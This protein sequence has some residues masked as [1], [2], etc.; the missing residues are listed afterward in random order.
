M[1]VFLTTA[2]EVIISLLLRWFFTAEY[3]ERLCAGPQVRFGEGAPD[4]GLRPLA[5]YSNL[6]ATASPNTSGKAPRWKIELPSSGVLPKP[7]PRQAK[8][9]KHAVNPL[10][11]L[12]ILQRSTNDCLAKCQ[13]IDTRNWR[14]R[15]PEPSSDSAA[16]DGTR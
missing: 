10:K 7:I 2:Y 14:T 6:R 16:A 4:R 12:S 5:A 1:L 13:G 11:A 8:P 3:T 15:A 9:H